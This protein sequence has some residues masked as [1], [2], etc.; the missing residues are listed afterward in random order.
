[1]SDFADR[2]SVDEAVNSS[3]L[4]ICSLRLQ[5]DR[6]HLQNLVH[7]SVAT[8]TLRVAL[9]NHWQT[10]VLHVRKICLLVRMG[11][12]VEENLGH[13]FTDRRRFH[14]QEVYQNCH[15]DSARLH[16]LQHGRFRVDAALLDLVFSPPALKSRETHRPLADCDA[17]TTLE[18]RSS[19][20][21]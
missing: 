1:M 10:T 21:V 8:K 16:R 5:G 3:V 11:M 19:R 15:Q 14:T 20:R 17:R 2:L 6:L 7:P 13:P 12:N 9:L 18:Q 4:V